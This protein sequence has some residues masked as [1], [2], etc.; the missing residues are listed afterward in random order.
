[1]AAYEKYSRLK[2]KRVD[3][4]DAI[5][6]QKPFTILFE[7]ASVCNFKCTCCFH[8]DPKIRTYLPRGLMRYADFKKIADDLAAW[9]GD[10][11]K[12]IRII[13]F[14]EPLLNRN[15]PRMIKL[16][17]ALD[18]SERV[19]ITTNASLLTPAISMRLIDSGLDYVRC[20]IYAVDQRG[21]EAVT[22]NRMRIEK[23]E[24]NIARL[25]RIRD[26]SGSR[27]PFIYVKMIESRDHREN[28]MFLEKFAAI[29][30][31]AALEKPHQWLSRSGSAA[32]ANRRVCPQPFK[33][34]SVHFNGD[35]ILCDP[36]W[37]GNTCIGNALSENIANLWGGSRIRAFWKMQLENRRHE[38][39]SC[40]RCSFLVDD[41][42]I[43]N[44]DG[45]SPGV[46]GE[47]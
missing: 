28:R 13:G 39:D 45:L 10:K 18:I 38:N 42:A 30:D 19:E 24:D 43:D 22:Q 7:P 2:L 20:S 9:D 35:V 8:S 6:L 26:D 3:L 11:I 34:L 41:Y 37:K 23:I 31:E 40:R 14:G 4:R 33:M 5:P 29:A 16:L 46:L 12:V 32:N 36:D 44:L 21:H 47:E 1:M 27:N 15:T 25:K 17:K